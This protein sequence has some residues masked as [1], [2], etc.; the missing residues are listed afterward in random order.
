MG[1]LGLSER[2]IF[3]DQFDD[4]DVRSVQKIDWKDVNIKVGDLR[5]DSA[6]WLLEQVAEKK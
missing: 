6:E 5:N 4:F 2:I 3:D 1:K